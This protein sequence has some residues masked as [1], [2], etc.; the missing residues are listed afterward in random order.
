MRT[1]QPNQRLPAPHHVAFAH[2]QVTQNAAFQALDFLHP[3]DWDYPPFAAGH[4]VD[5]GQRCPGNS[6]YDTAQHCP[7]QWP[8]KRM[9]GRP[10]RR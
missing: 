1:V 4:F 5:P 2:Q 10:V 3:A 7:Q 6:H 8:V 9:C